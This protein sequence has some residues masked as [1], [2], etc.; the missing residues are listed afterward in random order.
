VLLFGPKTI[1]KIHGK[2]MGKAF[3]NELC[4][5]AALR[6]NEALPGDLL[7][8]QG[9]QNVDQATWMIGCFSTQK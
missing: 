2:S 1:E 9:D 7:T 4:S 8:G 3:Q 6:L 5:Y